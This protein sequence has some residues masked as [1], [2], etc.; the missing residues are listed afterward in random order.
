MIYLDNAATSY[1]KPE[2]V[3]RAA[4][5]AMRIAA[6]PG[7]SAHR[8]ALDAARMVYRV[9]EQTAEWFGLDDPLRVVFTANATEALNFAILGMAGHGGHVV[10]TSM[11]HNS[12]L[13]PLHA[14]ESA[15]KIRCTV[16]EASPKG[17][18]SPEDIGSAICADTVLVIVNH[19]SNVLGTVQQVREIGRICRSAG[20]PLLVDASQS[21][22]IFPLDMVRDGIS[23]L[24]APG[25]KSLFGMQGTGVLL[26]GEGV[27]LEPV[28]RGGTGSLSSEL[29]QPGYLPDLL[30]SG[31]LNVPGIASLGAGLSWLREQGPEAVREAEQRAE[32]QFLEQ[33]G[34]NRAVTIYGPQDRR[35]CAP[36]VSLNIAGMDCAQAAARLDQEYGIAVRAGLHCAPLAHRT[37][38]TFPEGSVRFSFGPFHTGKEIERAA[39][40]VLEL[41]KAPLSFSLQ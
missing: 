26:L 28:L 27:E 21:A 22:G 19:A 24:A 32:R 38:G 33:L 15:G 1:P 16:V 41:A 17:L 31:T 12:V 29:D 20:K 11:E 37:A 5:Q 13:R 9:R 6:N 40:A 4:E 23:L 8:M 36:V 10:T 35:T 14:L 7:R 39:Q 18:V 30:E 25:H 3:Y 34:G 2:P